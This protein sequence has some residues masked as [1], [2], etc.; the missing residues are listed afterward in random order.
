MFYFYFSVLRAPHL[1][2]RTTSPEVVLVKKNDFHT[3]SEISVP[4]FFAGRISTFFDQ[5][6][7]PPKLFCGGDEEPPERPVVQGVFG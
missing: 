2:H 1:L 3:V 7:L 4:D 6:N 5:N